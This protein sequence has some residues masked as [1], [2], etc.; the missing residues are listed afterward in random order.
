MSV[1]RVGLQAGWFAIVLGLAFVI[2]SCNEPGSEPDD[3]FME[4]DMDMDGDNANQADD[5]ANTNDDSSDDRTPD[6]VTG[7]GTT[8]DNSSGMDVE[9]VFFGLEPT[10]KP[11]VRSAV[12][13]DALEVDAGDGPSNE[14]LNTSL[15]AVALPGNRVLFTGGFDFQERAVNAEAFLYDAA[16]D[17]WTVLPDMNQP[18]RD[19]SMTV[20]EDGR[21][22]IAGG[23]DGTDELR[24]TEFFDPSTMRFSAGPPML[25]DRVFHTATRLA[26][27]SVLIAG[28]GFDS[29][30]DVT[31]ERFDPSSNRFDPLGK[32]LDDARAAALLPDGSVLLVGAFATRVAQR[33]DPATRQFT[34]TGQLLSIHGLFPTATALADG[35][36]LVAGGCDRDPFATDMT[37]LF[38]PAT[39]EFSAGP[40]MSVARDGHV[41]LQLADGTVALLG[42]MDNGVIHDSIDI[43]DPADDTITAQAQ[44]MSI[45]RHDFVGVTL[46]P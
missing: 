9:R 10:V 41:A 21:V 43:F 16:E 14:R 6:A 18:R 37:E 25:T 11:R 30:S 40:R 44:K 19:H 5:N 3:P 7:G 39:G 42:G 8:N 33:F 2:P 27:G 28:G 23:F 38:D 32:M 26:D 13:A 45:G 15:A 20:L 31:A 22:L 24:S 12:S 34:A 17:E 1:R 46:T 35:R 4:D 36:V 29:D